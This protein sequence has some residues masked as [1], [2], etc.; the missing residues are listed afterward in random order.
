MVYEGEFE[1]KTRGESDIIDITSFVEA[2]LKKSG[3]KSGI[4]CVFIGGSTGAITTIEYEQG[5]I[6]DLKRAIE[7]IVPRNI[8]YEHDRAWGDGNGFS[9]VRSAILKTSL[10]IPVRGGDLTLGTWQQIVFIECDNRVRRRRILV[11]I[12]GE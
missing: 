5:V 6:N 8:S 4:C 12:V 7:R 1:I 3:V 10:C 9:H 11:Q 2:E